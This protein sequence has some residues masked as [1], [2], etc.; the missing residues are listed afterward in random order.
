MKK[1]SSLLKL[2]LCTVLAASM[3]GGC[4]NSTKTETTAAAES[5]AETAGETS[6][7]ADSAD[8]SYTIGIS[9]LAE[10]G[11]L[12][13]C[14]EGFIEGLAEEGFIE[15]ENL[16]IDYQN[17]QG[18]T[19][20]AS[21]IAQNFVSKKYDLVC[22][23]ATP[24]AMACYN[25]AQGTDIPTIFTAVSDPVAA[26]LVESLEAPGSNC[27][28]TSDALPVEDQLKMI[29]A[30]MPEA[31]TIGI[32]YTTSEV[33]SISTLETYKELAPKYDFEIVESGVS[34]SS[35]IP[36]AL[37]ALVTKVDCISNMTDNNVVNNLDTV[38]A[39]ATEAGIP[40]F[41]SEVEQVVNG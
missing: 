6:S 16:T 37:D 8:D 29:R 31:K 13:N 27:T 17:A 23:I 5:E 35:D 28:G 41:G 12:D 7:K 1:S 32:M 2:A 18:D 11:S 39:K 20:N 4:G 38:L 25:A 9:Q 34:S 33:N 10:H 3:L 21:V 22:A 40:V 24:S 15:G 14:R 26:E 19:S 36:I 30:M